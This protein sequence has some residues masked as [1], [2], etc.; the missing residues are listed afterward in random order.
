MV[1]LV[2]KTARAKVPDSA[3]LVES[4]FE[5]LKFLYALRLADRELAL[6]LKWV[7]LKKYLSS[8]GS[9]LRLDTERYVR[10][11]LMANGR[12]SQRLQYSRAVEH[13][14]ERLDCDV[15]L[16]SRGHDYSELL[17]FAVGEF[18]GNKS[19][20]DQVALERLFVLLAKSV[21]SLARELN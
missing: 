10:S 15:R 8:E 13:W 18:G 16:S 14:R 1:D 20:S 12:S 21:H 7:A 2:I 6:S 17:A 4:L 9:V 3:A 19:F 5:N 11:T